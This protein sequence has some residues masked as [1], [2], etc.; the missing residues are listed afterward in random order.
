MRISSRA[1]L[2]AACIALVAPLSASCGANAKP[3]WTA[4]SSPFLLHFSSVVSEVTGAQPGPGGRLGYELANGSRHTVTS[5]IDKHATA[6]GTTYRVATDEPGRTA[7]VAVSRTPRG[8]HVSWRLV[9]E[10]GVT[11]L[12]SALQSSAKSE[13]FLGTGTQQR[14][15]LLDG[16]IV[17]LKVAYSC[18]RSVVTPFYASSAGYGV[19]FETTAV[20]Q[21][22]FRGT[23]DGMACDDANSAHPLCSLIGA[24]DR[25]EWCF[26]TSSLSY[27]VFVGSPLQVL[28]DYRVTAGTMPLPA[29]AELAAIKWRDKVAGWREVTDDVSQFHRLG[30]PLGSVL[31]DNP[32]ERDGCLGS[33]AFDP[34]QFPQPA[35][36]IGRIHAGG[37]RVLVWVSPWVTPTAPCRALAGLPTG[38]TIPAGRY[39]AIDFTNAHAAA[40]YRAKIAAL[41]RLGV[42]GF[43]GDRGDE[44]DMESLTFAHGTGTQEHNAYAEQFAQA[45]VGGARAA[46]ERAPLT[47]FRAAGPKSNVGVW[48][49]DQTPDFDGLRQAVRSLASLGASG[50]ALTGSDV[51]GYSTLSGK[52][53]LTPE[54]FARWSEVGA[55]SPIFEVGGHDRAARFWE[56]GAQATAAARKSVL[57]HYALFPYLYELARA[58]SRTGS[59]ILAPLALETP[60][61]ESAW[62]AELELRI[63]PSLLAA[64]V[65][66]STLLAHVYLPRGERWVDLTWGTAV[67]G[68]TS[69]LRPTPL[70]ELPLYLRA[71]DTIPFAPRAYD[72]WARPWPLDALQVA[73]RAGWL[74]AAS[75]VQLRGA[76]RESAV[77]FALPKPPAHV[78]VDGHDVPRAPDA[79]ALRSLASGWLWTAQPFH[80][81]LVKVT[82]HAGAADVSVH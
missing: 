9:P 4:S 11:T 14:S 66:S 21:I 39:D 78:S 51:G 64:P 47:M 13:H 3:P 58:S 7:V 35:Q 48:T 71:G 55:I 74:T 57:L 31:I 23:H 82:P 40:A 17:Q 61:D 2:V 59:P 41:V 32:W 24:P 44:L 12:Y 22:Q 52:K 8:V 28:Q 29:P 69:L 16:Q 10:T 38:S 67:D 36:A 81:A 73:G 19:Y 37:H 65:T 15:V 72:I 6:S 75:K 49:G 43:K 5:L 77:L 50:V 1:A 79:A 46:D 53:I 18:G 60:D 26:K 25:V 30:I 20:G 56:L 42:D 62:K 68:G 70:D 63:G 80:G 76:P 34:A 27:D 45:V 33:L 54:V